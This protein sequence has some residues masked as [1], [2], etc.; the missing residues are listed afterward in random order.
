MIHICHSR[1]ADENRMFRLISASSDIML[2]TQKPNML[3]QLPQMPNTVSSKLAYLPN[4]LNMLNMFN[5]TNPWSWRS[6]CLPGME[7]LEQKIVK[8][9]ALLHL[10]GH[11]VGGISLWWLARLAHLHCLPSPRSCCCKPNQ[12]MQNAKVAD[13]PLE[14]TCKARTWKMPMQTP[15]RSSLV[16]FQ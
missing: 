9:V 2:R 12:L 4:M 11:F 10:A 14:D 6:C 13:A 3:T 16:G 8:H 5:Q 7:A 1:P 15:M